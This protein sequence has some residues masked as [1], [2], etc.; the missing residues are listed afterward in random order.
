[1]C[2]SASASFTASW[3]LAII[4][5]TALIKIKKSTQ[6][7]LATVPLLF[8]AQQ[9]IEGLLWLSFFYD[10]LASW[11]SV[12]TYG[13]L[14]FAFIVWPIWIPLSLWLQEQNPF[15]KKILFLFAMIGIITSL[16]LIGWLLYAGTAVS[17][18]SCHI[19]YQ[20]EIPL[21][22]YYL[23][24]ALYISATVG[25]FFNSSIAHAKLFGCALAFS[26]LVSY[27]WYYQVLVSVWCF[28]AA[29]LSAALLIILI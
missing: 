12:F 2:F 4:G 14:F 3:F 22:F 20:A 16:A 26:Y 23:G 28:F 27:Y 9:G 10:T 19:W 25:S 17:I 24:T 5:A 21:A 11:Q 29:L 8:A 15:R 1:M 13:F 18:V 6:I 7:M